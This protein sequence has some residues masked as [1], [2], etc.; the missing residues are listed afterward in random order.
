MSNSKTDSSRKGKNQNFK[1]HAKSQ[2]AKAASAPRQSIVPSVQWESTDDLLLPG[3]LLQAYNQT[4]EV[5]VHAFQQLG[6]IYQQIVARNIQGDA[7]PNGKIKLKYLW[8]N[9]E[10]VSEQDLKAFQVKMAEI[11]TLQQKHQQE[12][13][14]KA[15]VLSHMKETDLVTPGGQPL[16]EENLEEESKII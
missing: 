9:G 8:N 14:Q 15:A 5:M 13:N 1:Q 2:A 10:E 12:I 6:Q 4:L 3:N 16:T 11:Q 7:N